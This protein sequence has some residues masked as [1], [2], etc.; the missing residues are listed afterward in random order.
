MLATDPTA[1]F[2]V[3]GTV[4]IDTPYQLPF[5]TLDEPVLDPDF[6]GMPDLV[7]KCFKYC[8]DYLQYWNMPE[9]TGPANGGRP[10]SIKA[11]NKSFDVAPGQ[12]LHLS[13]AGE[14]AVRDGK[15]YEGKYEASDKP[16]APPPGVMLRCLK[17]SQKPAG[18]PA[19]RDCTIDTFRD[20]P[21]LGYEGRYPDFI[22]ATIDIDSSHFEMFDRT[23]DQ[24][25]RAARFKKMLSENDSKLTDSADG[26]SDRSAQTGP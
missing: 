8:D 10:L 23:N 5:F 3:A 2:T 21:L 14:W 22:K 13:N 17:R 11:G 16:I 24:L 12:V 15:T 9:W 6:S 19:D 25:V 18:A 7:Q 26:D 1:L 4:L 20:E